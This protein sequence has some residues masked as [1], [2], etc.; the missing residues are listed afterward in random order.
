VLNVKTDA[1]ALSSLT[2]VLA[3][4][5]GSLASTDLL[6]TTPG[7][8]LTPNAGSSVSI[9]ASGAFSVDQ[10]LTVP[11]A[12][13]LNAAGSL[14]I[15]STGSVASSG[16]NVTL[17]D[18]SSFI[19]N[20]G[21]AAVS[22]ANGRWLIYSVDPD[23][24]IRG[25][26]AYNFKQYA[27]S[28]GVTAV[29]QATGNGVLYSTA[30]VITP[31]A[32]KTYDGNNSATVASSVNG[33]DGDV[34]ALSYSSAAY[35]NAN[36]GT[37]KTVTV[38]SLTMT[39]ATNGAAIVYGYTLGSVIGTITPRSIT[40][41]AGAQSRVYGDA[42]PALGYVI[43][44]GGLLNND[45]LTGGLA[46]SAT[47]T[48]GVGSYGITLGSLANSNYTLAYTGANLTITARP[49]TVTANALSQV[50]GDAIPT[51]TYVISGGNLVNGDGLLGGLAT[52]AT[53]ATG[54]GSYGI[55]QGSLANSNYALTYAT[56]N[57]TI[58]AR[59]ITVT[60][61]AQSQVYGNATPALSYT[62]GGSGLVNNDSLSGSLATSAT[63]ASGVG[64]YG[65]TQGSL[66]N[67][68]YALTYAAANLTITARPI[69][70]TAN[71]QSQVYGN[72]TPA[73]T[74]TVGGSGIVNGDSLS[75]SL[76]TSA[77]AVSGVGSY[78]ITQGNLGNSNC[79]VTYTGANLSITGRQITVTAD[80]LSRVYGDANPTFTYA[81][82]GSGLVNGD[83]L[84]G[85]LATS[86]TAVSGVGSYGITQGNLGNSNYAVTYTG[87]NLSV[88]ARPITVTADTL[89]RI[90]GDANPTLTYSVGA[91]G[92]V[93]GDTLSGSL[94]TSATAATGVGS[95][96]I[97][98][99]NLAASSNNYALTYTGANLTITARPITVAA[100]AQTQVYGDANPAL[101][102]ALTGGNLVNGDSLTGSLATSATN[103]TGVGSYGITQGSLAASN[104]NYAL[105]YVG[106]NLTI[107]A[108]PITVTADAQSQVYGN[109][110]PA[111]TYTVG[112]LGLVNGDTLAGSL[113]TDATPISV[114]GPYAITQGTLI[115]A[116]NPNYAIAYTGATLVVSAAVSPS[117]SAPAATPA[118]SPF[119]VTTPAPSTPQ[120]ASISFQLDQSATAVIAPIAVT[121]VRVA[122]KSDQT[123]QTAARRNPDD[124]IVTGS[125]TPQAFKSA[126]G[127]IY[128]PLSQY[129]AAQYTDKTLPG[130]ESQ[131]GEAAI[132][133]MLLRGALGLPDT[134]KIDNLF[135]PGKGFLWRGANWENPLTDKVRVSDG[136]D[137]TGAP[138]ES[139]P[140]QPGTTDFAALLGMGPIILTGHPNAPNA[141]PFSL[142]GVTRLEEGIVANDPGTGL[143]VLLNY[144]SETKTLGSIVSVFDA[145]TKTWTKL[146][147]VKPNHDWQSQAQLDQLTAWSGDRYASV[148]VPH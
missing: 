135:E 25:G 55:T 31:T 75:G 10:N 146:A 108:R 120:Q 111:L 41:T 121:P 117:S 128:K 114:A 45:S 81:I 86:A 141:A 88:T 102:S 96:G 93:N 116:L 87:A 129:D 104:N 76:A 52:S 56:A 105:T 17:V 51:L 61:N 148:S 133:T 70:V 49:I 18:G 60:A 78:G 98:Q 6:F 101:T 32:S 107:T 99:G 82:G 126:D 44:G 26:L 147:D 122:S 124:D 16:S 63:A 119:I 139:Y 67:S 110:N 145:K 47:A 4:V 35:D 113:S 100:N 112:P 66:A 46:T 3:G 21:A 91:Q 27:A 1:T 89:S 59:P 92:M 20:A 97:A 79:A 12:L 29:A 40:A 23:L 9:A 57:L 134:P 48:T 137:H 73:L 24:D 143:Q 11:N 34:V 106:A 15:A 14:T 5:V 127:I 19:N 72:A 142:L 138:G 95:Y 77:T 123:T 115:N 130:F 90:Y 8:V 103:T 64:S 50:Y 43:G 125:I 131:A 74:Y 132:F 65:I 33:I 140:I 84:S 118:T 80:T 83:N 38:N 62:I 144:N 22:A 30:P 136:A 7:G 28:Y 36:A 94:A 37:G 53:T 69:T 13:L 71:A 39:S 54:V 109:A 2:S 42:N 85:S 58:T 68:N